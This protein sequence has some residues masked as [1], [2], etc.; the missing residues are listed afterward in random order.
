MSPVGGWR[1]GVLTLRSVRFNCK[2]TPN[3]TPK[4][5]AKAAA[6][7]TDQVALRALIVATNTDDFGLWPMEAPSGSSPSYKFLSCFSD[8][9]VETLHGEP[10]VNNKCTSECYCHID[11]SR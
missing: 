3:A 4:A 11:A 7:G 5:T 9:Q 8:Y 2:A 10:I 6:T 1:R